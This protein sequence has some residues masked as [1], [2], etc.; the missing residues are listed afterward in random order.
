M[1]QFLGLWW[2]WWT[3][4]DNNK[5]VKTQRRE[6]IIFESSSRRRHFQ[7]ML[8]MVKRKSN[9]QKQFMGEFRLG[10][11]ALKVRDEV[12]ESL[13]KASKLEPKED[14]RIL[15]V[16][17]VRS[18]KG[19]DEGFFAAKSQ[20]EVDVLVLTVDTLCAVDLPSFLSNW[21]REDDAKFHKVLVDDPTNEVICTQELETDSEGE[22]NILASTL[23]G[24]TFDEIQKPCKTLH[25]SPWQLKSLNGVWFLAESQPRVQLQFGSKVTI[26]FARDGERQRWRRHLASVLR[27]QERRKPDDKAKDSQGW[28]VVP[29]GK[30]ELEAVK[31]QKQAK[32]R[33]LM[34]ER[35]ALTN[36][37]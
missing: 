1:R 31:K 32:Q 15:N 10:V 3:E 29:T 19:S 33:E 30:T 28:S 37:R 14:V 36:G 20:A 16:A 27:S 4:A 26:S 6:V 13:Q 17:F 5:I 24:Q 22:D 9:I 23:A 2:V 35:P 21:A 12:M 11:P 8:R 34:P 25:G 7:H 18:P